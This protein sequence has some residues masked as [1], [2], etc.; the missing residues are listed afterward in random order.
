[1]GKEQKL[2]DKN[3]SGV[4]QLIQS[5]NAWA[6]KLW[7]DGVSNHWVPFEVDMTK[8]VKQWKD[9]DFFSD[10]ER[11]LVKRTLGLF[12]AGESLVNN[13]IASVERIYITDGA[14]KQ[15]LARKDFEESLHN[16]TVK[17][18]CE[19]YDLDIDGVAEAYKNIPTI[20]DKD[21][22]LMKSLD[23]FDKNF[24]I[25]TKEGKQKFVKN[26]FIFY[27]ICEGTWFFTNFALILSL[28][29]Q[30][31]LPGLCDQI[32]YT[33]RD[34]ALHVEFGA[35]VISQT[36]KEYPEIWTKDFEK[37]LFDVMKEGV[38]IEEA[39]AKDIIPNGVLGVS[40]DMLIQYVRYLANTRL[41]SVGLEQSLEGGE[42]NP[43]TWLEEQ[44]NSTGMS[45]F[46]ERREKSYQSAGNLSD[47]LDF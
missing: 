29:R 7:R 11:L 6:L 5:P 28:G 46:F 24:D 34:E 31:K 41:F 21:E 3:D 25:T 26:M 2:F 15:Y 38:E 20:K 4:S 39:Y 14:C 10:E 23:S 33:L 13:S 1:M 37:E 19:S 30:N 47:D 35:N 42:K 27:M 36:R 44:Q 12:S 18:C 43:F 22:F 16:W 32:Q 17:V 45:A 8:D 40:I 9:K